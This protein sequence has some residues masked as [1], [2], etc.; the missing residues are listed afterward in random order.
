MRVR[1][2]AG[3]Q[4]QPPERP[5]AHAHAH[6]HASSSARACKA[7]E[8]AHPRMCSLS[9]RWHTFGAGVC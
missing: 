3:T 8:R 4:T 6:A 1:A 2:H 7:C 5:L 9:E